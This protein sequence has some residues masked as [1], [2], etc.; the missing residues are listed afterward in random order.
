MRRLREQNGAPGRETFSGTPACRPWCISLTNPCCDA[1]TGGHSPGW[2]IG[3]PRWRP[4]RPVA[5]RVSVS[6]RFRGCRSG[7][8][9]NLKAAQS[10]AWFNKRF[11]HFHAGGDYAMTSH[12]TIAD[13]PQS[14][15]QTA[16]HLFDHWFDPIEAGLRDRARECN[17]APAVVAQRSHSFGRSQLMPV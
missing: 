8:G 17:G 15:R 11:R 10:P 9:G 5:V 12:S 4:E 14:E 7:S 6:F 16:V 2:K 1:S 13:E 3:A